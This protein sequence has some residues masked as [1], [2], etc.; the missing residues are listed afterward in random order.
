MQVNAWFMQD[1]TIY[2][3]LYNRFVR[4]RMEVTN[5]FHFRNDF[6]SYIFLWHAF[7]FITLLIYCQFPL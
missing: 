7:R 2:F 6:Q 3:H 4:L 5:L 1:I